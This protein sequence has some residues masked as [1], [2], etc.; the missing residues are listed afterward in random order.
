M[1][2]KYDAD[3]VIRAIRV[4]LM[5]STVAG[6]PMR[7]DDRHRRPG[8]RANQHAIEHK[9]TRQIATDLAFA[10]QIVACQHVDLHGRYAP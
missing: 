3:T 10:D 4:R 1:T 5:V 8:H 6:L 2:G 7:S 9:Q